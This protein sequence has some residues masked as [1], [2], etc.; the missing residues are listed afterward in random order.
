[1]I[2]KRRL[3]DAVVEMTVYAPRVAAKCQAGQFFMVRA[4]ERGERVPFT[5]CDWSRDEGWV[6]FIFMVVGKTTSMLADL[7]VG[8]CVRDVAGPLGRP[9]LGKVEVVSSGCS[10]GLPELA[11]GR[12][13]LSDGRPEAGEPQRPTHLSGLAPGGRVAV[14][15]GGVGAAVAFPVAR[16]LCEAG[17]RVRVI[18]GARTAELLILE[19]EL[20]GLPLEELRIVTDD[21]SAGRK[22][23]VTAPLHELCG[24]GLVDH[25][26]IVGP[27]IMMKFAAATALEAG[28]PTTVSLNPLMIDGTGMCGA[29][30]V[31]IDGAT[32]FACVDGPDFAAA[33]VDWGELMSR[34]RS[35]LDDERLAHGLWQYEQLEVAR[36]ERERGR[37]RLHA[38]CDCFDMDVDEDAVEAMAADDD[39]DDEGGEDE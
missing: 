26:F 21:G 5:F 23:L 13:V 16:A 10:G 22:G 3:S 8:E 4:W 19:D 2:R 27:A 24:A 33:S 12:P 29:C 37:E 11:D 36:G 28:V 20:R 9:T 18:V 15:G 31:T 14:V 34:Q 38:N 1:V 7:E 17:M 35:Y 25:A 32:K 6:R 30:R 39:A